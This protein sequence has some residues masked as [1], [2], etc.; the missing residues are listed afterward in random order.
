M[1]KSLLNLSLEFHFSKAKLIEGQKEIKTKIPE[2]KFK[3]NSKKKDQSSKEQ[4]MLLQKASL[5]HS[6]LKFCWRK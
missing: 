4:K 2:S 5:S 1:E 3:Q 6:I